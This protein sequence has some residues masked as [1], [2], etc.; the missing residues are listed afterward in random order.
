MQQK[1]EKVRE[2]LLA[3]HLKQMKARHTAELNATKP[4]SGGGPVIASAETS[5]KG[6]G[7]G[8]GSGSA[9]IQQD[10]EFLLYYQA[11]Q[12]KIKEAWSFAGNNPNLNATVTFGINPDGSLNSVR[13]TVSSRDPSFDDSV[14]RAIRRAAPFSA[15]PTKYNQQFAQGIEAVFKLGDLSS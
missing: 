1:L 12:K 2:Q 4:N 13:V 5:G 11:V 15:P 3:E 8:A 9:G 6:Y 10:P 7:V 14:I